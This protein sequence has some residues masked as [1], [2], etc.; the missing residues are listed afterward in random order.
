[1]VDTGVEKAKL[2][3]EKK[4]RDVMPLAAKDRKFAKRM[5]ET[6]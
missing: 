2:H 4:L 6:G 5:M 1:M 3:H